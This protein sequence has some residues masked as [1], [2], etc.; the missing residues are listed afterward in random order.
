[1]RSTPILELKHIAF[2]LFLFFISNG[3]Y[4]DNVLA[5]KNSDLK[6]V[7]LLVSDL[8][9]S[10]TIYKDTLGMEVFE[11]TKSSLDSYSYPVFNLPKQA[12]IRFATLNIGEDKR[13]FALTE[14]KNVTLPSNEGIRMNTVVISVS[15]LN[16]KYK[17]I[18]SMGLSR[19]EID[20]DITPEG[21]SFSEFSFLDFDGHLIVLYEI[22]D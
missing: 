20:M 15:G 4:S 9:Q 18:G 5:E 19:T 8:E 7:N 16:N 12:E 17:K 3:I 21:K 6:R 22:K 11:I 1:L 2:V 10:L 14:V 13:A